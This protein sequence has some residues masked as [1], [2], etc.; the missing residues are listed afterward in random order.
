MIFTEVGHL[1]HLHT[2]PT[3]T[4]TTYNLPTYTLTVYTLTASTLT[5]YTLPPYTLTAYTLT[6]YTHTP[7]PRH[8]MAR[9]S[10]MWQLIICSM[11]LQVMVHGACCMVYDV[12]D[13]NK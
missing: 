9:V 10:R 11:V 5:V 4:F 2:L 12:W 1:T 6:T 3:S 13:F 7:H 8:G